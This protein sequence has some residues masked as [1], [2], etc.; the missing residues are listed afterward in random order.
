MLVFRGGKRYGVEVKYKDAPGVTKSMRI[1]SDD[2]K[3]KRLIAVYLGEQAYDLDK[4]S[5]RCRSPEPWRHLG[6]LQ[7]KKNHA[8]LEP[9]PS[10]S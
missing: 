5:R 9:R 4:K 1:A 2:L 10:I 6:A 7:L 3:L 8:I